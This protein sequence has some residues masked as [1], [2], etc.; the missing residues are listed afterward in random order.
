MAFGAHLLGQPAQKSRQCI[1]G[2]NPAQ[3][4]N[5]EILGNDFWA[6]CSEIL[7]HG[8]S[9]KYLSSHMAKAQVKDPWELLLSGQKD[10][11]NPLYPVTSTWLSFLSTHLPTCLVSSN[12]LV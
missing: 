9:P 1:S 2:L 12:Q 10:K 5:K 11:R 4:R 8:N 6:I 7:G 3:V